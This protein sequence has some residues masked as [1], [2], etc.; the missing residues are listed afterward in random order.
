MLGR[1]RWVLL[2]LILGTL[3]LGGVFV[4]SEG[5][6]AVTADG[7]EYSSLSWWVWPLMLFGV[8]FGLGIVAVLGGVGGGVLFVPIVGGFFP[9][10]LDF[11]RSAG[12]PSISLEWPSRG[13]GAAG[14]P[15]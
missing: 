8:T 15:G 4:A 2:G 1:L 5:A 14:T 6:W 13:G 12:W 3:V 9:F 11:V 7:E 10:H